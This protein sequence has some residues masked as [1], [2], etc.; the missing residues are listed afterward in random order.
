MNRASCTERFARIG[1]L[2]ALSLAAAC[3]PPQ[4]APRSEPGP[5]ADSR[6]Q[7]RSASDRPLFKP[8]PPGAARGG[9]FVLALN[10]PVDPTRAPLAVNHAERTIY[11]NLYETLVNLT[12]DGDLAAGLADR[13]QRLDGGRRWRLDLRP[14]AVLWDGTLVTA[15]VVVQ[16]WHRSAVLAVM[17]GRPLPRFWLAIA[18]G[19]LLPLDGRTLEIRLNQPLDDLPRWLAHPDLAVAIEREGWLWPLGSGPCRLSAETAAPSPDLL[20]RP[21]DHHPQ[22]PAWASLTFRIL[23]GRDARD[24]LAAGVDCAVF[25]AW[26]AA[27]YYA[28]LGGVQTA[29]LPWHRLYALLLPPAGSLDPVVCAGAVHQTALVAASCPW[30]SLFLHDCR[31]AVC[32]QIST[33]PDPDSLAPAAFEP[34]P[35]AATGRHLEHLAGDRDARALAERLAAFLPADITPLG[36]DG[37][38]LAASLQQGRAAGYVIGLEDGAA[39]ACLELGLLMAQAGWLGQGFETSADPCRLAAQLL[40]EGRIV[41]L[42]AIQAQ[43]AWRRPLAGL[44]TAHGGALLVAGLGLSELPPD[45]P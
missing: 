7:T 19:G 20:C 4:P 18:G 17:A 39:S 29:S 12:N 21:N 11:A 44:R 24:L 40:R 15:R 2:A 43:L 25:C 1:V 34:A 16:A 30:T 26:R 35:A 27:D 38:E 31:P 45:L 41:P 14:D 33:Q 37:P 42:A 28:Q 32:P 36:R 10:E 6:P 3:G 22:R 5:F 9:D 13:W 23:T 8:L